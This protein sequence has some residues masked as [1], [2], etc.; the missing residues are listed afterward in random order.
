MSVRSECRSRAC[1]GRGTGGK[2]LRATPDAHRMNLSL[3]L[4]TMAQQWP[5]RPAVSW[6]QGVL[7][8]AGLQDQVERI[9]G[10]F[11]GR[12]ALRSGAR[13]SLAMENCPEFLPAL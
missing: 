12:L 2:V 5:D 11:L 9:A 10:A 4:R 3:T 7:S 6:E 1:L 13:V 8:Y